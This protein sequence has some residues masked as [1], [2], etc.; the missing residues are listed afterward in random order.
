VE[1]K[2]FRGFWHFE[3]SF[4]DATIHGID[5]TNEGTTNIAVKSGRQEIM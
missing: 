1:R 2:I 3:N 4:S 5:G